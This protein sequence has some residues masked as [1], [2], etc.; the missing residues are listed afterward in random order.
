MLWIRGLIFTVLVPG[1]VAFYI[2]RAILS[3]A[4][5]AGGWWQLG[6][7]PLIAG[8]VLFLWCVAR[9]LLAGGTPAPFFVGPLRALVGREPADLV[10]TGPYRFSRNPMY[11]G[12]LLIIFGQAILYRSA[13][14]ATYGLVM[15]LAFHLVVVFIEE[16]HLEQV[17]GAEYE[18]FRRQVRRWL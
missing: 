7:V 14:L 17:H 8:L 5:L 16:P 18:R 2:P 4:P 15:W 10:A 3:G 9:F 13:D 12:V 11:V 6:W 1:T